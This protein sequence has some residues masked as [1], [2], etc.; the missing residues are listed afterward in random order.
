MYEEFEILN[1]RMNELETK[2][3]ELEEEIIYLKELVNNFL[4]VM[5]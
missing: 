2:V 5:Q 3:F 1:R 4:V